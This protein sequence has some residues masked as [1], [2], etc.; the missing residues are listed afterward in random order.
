MDKNKRR[1]LQEEYKQLKTY[2]GVVQIINKM[3]K[4]FG[5]IA[6]VRR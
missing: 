4:R 5:E 1:E 3:E 6:A 2:M